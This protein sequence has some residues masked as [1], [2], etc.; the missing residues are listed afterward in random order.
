MITLCRP[1]STAALYEGMASARDGRGK[2]SPIAADDPNFIVGPELP[3]ISSTAVRAAARAGDW[4]L[5]RKM[6]HEDVAMWLAGRPW[7]AQRV[8]Q[9]SEET[10]DAERSIEKLAL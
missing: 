3:D 5:L 1:G 6:V 8:E 9:G 7:A 4:A 10:E 2:P